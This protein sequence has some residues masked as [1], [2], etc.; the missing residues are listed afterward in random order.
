M[1]RT[2]IPIFL[3]IVL[4]FTLPCLGSDYYV[5]AVSGDDST[6]DGSS[7][8]PWKTITKALSMV[9]VHQEILWL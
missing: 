9:Q 1:S 4:L 8:N 2:S 5:D 6:G 3:I 7:G